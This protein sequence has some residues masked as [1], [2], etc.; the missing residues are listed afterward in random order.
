MPTKER[1]AHSV[2][3]HDCNGA[4]CQLVTVLGIVAT[5]NFDDWKVTEF[6]LNGFEKNVLPF[7]RKQCPATL[8]PPVLVDQSNDLS[9]ISQAAE[10]SKCWQ[11][12]RRF[13]CSMVFQFME[14]ENFCD[15]FFSVQE[16]H[17]WKVVISF[18]SCTCV[19]FSSHVVFHSKTSP[20]I[21]SRK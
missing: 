2:G 3:S 12:T 6:L 19:W 8:Q 16:E 20:L 21:L 17:Q 15:Q 18:F 1:Q 5:A 11:T 10:S 9:L 13:A 7:C 4:L 14:Q